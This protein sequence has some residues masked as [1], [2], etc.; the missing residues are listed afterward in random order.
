VT[1]LRDGAARHRLA[2]HRG[3]FRAGDARG[4]RRGVYAAPERRRTA[5]PDSLAVALAA[6][7]RDADAAFRRTVVMVSASQCAACPSHAL[8]RDLA[9]RCRRH[10][11]VQVGRGLL[12]VNGTPSAAT[13]LRPPGRPAHPARRLDPPLIAGGVAQASCAS[14]CWRSA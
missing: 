1:C 10:D 12:A 11:P 5:A 6:C 2:R 8:D 4:Q 14:A 9:A 3:F 13:R 7:A